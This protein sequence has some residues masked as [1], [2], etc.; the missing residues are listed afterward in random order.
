M[1]SLLSH[2][3]LNPFPI[4]ELPPPKLDLA[5]LNHIRTMSDSQQNPWSYNP[6]APNITYSTYFLE[7]AY[8][9]GLSVGWILY[10]TPA[11]TSVYLRSFCLFG[12]FQV[13]SSWW[14]F[15]V[16]SGYLTPSIAEGSA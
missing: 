6:N 8:S 11:Y 9:A 13:L 14:P 5:F 16:W 4:S 3:T 1:Q 12:L 15:N 2:R 7:K 10:G